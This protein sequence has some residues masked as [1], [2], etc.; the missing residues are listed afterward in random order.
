MARAFLPVLVA[1]AMMLTACSKPNAPVVATPVPTPSAP[2]VEASPT[3]PPPAK[4]QPPASQTVNQDAPAGKA[5]VG[6]GT[7]GPAPVKVEPLIKWYPRG[8][9][10]PL[11]S[12]D[13]AAQGKK[14]VVLTFDDGPVPGTTPQ[15]LDTLK[16]H[17]V[18]AMFFVTG[19]SSVNRDLLERI[20]REGHVIGPHTMTHPNLA[21][22]TVPEMRKEL[23][24][25]NKLIEEVTGYKPKHLRP[26]FGAYNQQVIDLVAEYGQTVLTWTDGSLDW[27][28]TKDGYK[29]PKL[30]VDEVMKQ[31][32]PG[33][34]VLLH[35]TLRHTAEAL[36]ELIK[37]IKAE[38]YEFIVLQ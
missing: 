17:N 13:P 3:T 2:V 4:V 31:L 1:A 6:G 30:V 16:E 10:L 8:I 14:V 18:K 15:I 7:T 28:G 11:T 26:P 19:Y 33:A 20:H 37:Q 21:K 5:P 34:V 22:L 36:P 29:E 12:D 27:E 9:G 35:D 23:E 38:G 25:L 24:P 32:H